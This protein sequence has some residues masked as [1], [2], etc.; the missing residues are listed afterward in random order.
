MEALSFGKPALISRG[1]G[2]SVSLP[3]EFLFDPFDQNE[4]ERKIEQLFDSENY[5]NAVL[6]VK[7]IPMNQSWQD[8]TN[9]HLNLI[10]QICP[11]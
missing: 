3:E 4:L 10:N 11:K 9:A 6:K 8:V 5:K 1:N 7:A 2:L